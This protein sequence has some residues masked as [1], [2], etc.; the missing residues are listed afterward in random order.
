MAASGRCSAPSRQ[1]TTAPVL[2]VEH[3]SDDPAGRLGSWLQEKGCRLE[4]V[5]CH[6]GEQ[7]PRSLSGLAGLVV[8]GGAM[9]AYDDDD[10][11]WLPQTRRLLSQATR[12]DLPTLAVCL[13]HQLLAVANHGRVERQ[14]VQQAGVTAVR[15]TPAAADDPLFAELGADASALHW[16]HDL[17]VEAPAGSVVLSRS[18]AGLQ[19]IRLGSSVWGVQF[20]PEVDVETVDLWARADVAAGQLDAR[21]A[22]TG[23]AGLAEADARLFTLWRDFAYRF[24]D[25]LSRPRP[26]R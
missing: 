5:R 7:L 9:G 2:V 15:P 1:G 20:H 4:V 26:G 22:A 3:G 16:N 19:A 23:L 21:A 6:L 13:G 8:L 12:Q 14:P 25:Q 24:A 17:V 11:P 10:A 18:D